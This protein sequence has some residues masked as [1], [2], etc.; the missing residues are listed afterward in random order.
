MAEVPVQ[1]KAHV[2]GICEETRC[3]R[4]R[5]WQEDARAR[6]SDHCPVLLDLA[7]DAD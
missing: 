2:T 4:L 3:D 1:A 7:A 5:N 6:L